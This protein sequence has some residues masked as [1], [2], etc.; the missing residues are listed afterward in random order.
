[1]EVS[2]CGLLLLIRR[3][4]R[5]GAGWPTRRISTSCFHQLYCLSL[6]SHIVAL[7]LYPIW[8]K[9]KHSTIP[10]RLPPTR[11]SCRFS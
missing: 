11:H 10:S 6:P 4:R 2:L 3:R 1:M 5:V 9:G 7:T 8:S